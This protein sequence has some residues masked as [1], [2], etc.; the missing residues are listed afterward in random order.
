[1]QISQLLKSKTVWGGVLVGL[2]HILQVAQTGLLGPK[3]AGIAQGLGII[4]AAVGV[5]DA[6]HKTAAP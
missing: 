5:R 1:M 2:G 3:A 4:L 6:I